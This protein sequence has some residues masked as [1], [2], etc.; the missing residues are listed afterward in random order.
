M[1]HKTTN[2][3]ERSCKQFSSNRSLECRSSWSLFIAN[4]V[5]CQ[6]FHGELLFDWDDDVCFVLDQHVYS[7][8]WRVDPLGHITKPPMHWLLLFRAVCLRENQIPIIVWFD[9]GSNQLTCIYKHVNRYNAEAVLRH[10][11]FRNFLQLIIV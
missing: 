9:R 5:I 10:F 1:P 2:I 7:D 4:W 11:E 3:I 6:L 8:S